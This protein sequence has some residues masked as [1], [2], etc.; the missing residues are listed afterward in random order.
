[1]DPTWWNSLNDLARYAVVW[2]VLIVILY[3]VERAE[4]RIKDLAIRQNAAAQHSH[5]SDHWAPIKCGEWELTGYR[6]LNSI[7]VYQCG[8]HTL[9]LTHE[10]YE[11]SGIAGLDNMISDYWSTALG[12]LPD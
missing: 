1:M 3:K 7:A 5:Y 6:N 10:L 11:D 12:K 2:F 9:H 8:T 4:G